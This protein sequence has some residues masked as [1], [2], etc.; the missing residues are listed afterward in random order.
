MDRRKILRYGLLAILLAALSIALLVIERQ[1]R[2][3]KQRLETLR[4]EASDLEKQRDELVALRD[5][6][7]RDYH[8]A[9]QRKA[10]EQLLFL[11]PDERI[12]SELAPILREAG[13]VGNI[14]LSGVLLPGEP[15]AIGREQ[16]DEL[17]A[18]GW[19]LCLICDSGEDFADWDRQIAQRLAQAQIEKPRAVYFAEGLYSGALEEEIL[20]CG[21]TVAI[22][23]GEDGVPAIAGDAGEGP[24]LPGAHPWNFAGIKTQINSNIRKGG[25][26]VF[27]VSFAEERELYVDYAFQSML[28]YIAGPLASGE[29]RVTG[30]Q[31]GREL[32]DPER[33]GIAAATR[34]WEQRDAELDA[35]I[36]DLN[37]QIQEIYEKWD[38][39]AERQ[40]GAGHD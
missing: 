10:T 26:Q 33:N 31:Q 4:E 16:L 27:T 38:S 24:W 29:L 25:D 36:H 3:M 13:C 11:E 20:A 30:I 15:G 23:H 8:T 14:G 1:D 22:H 40:K 17:L 37:A 2:E 9:T 34:S 28:D 32:H 35:Q 5:R 18:E 7:E 39:G 12:Y 6:E 19:E 21:Y